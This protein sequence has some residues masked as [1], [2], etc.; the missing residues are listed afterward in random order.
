M[1]IVTWQVR[2]QWQA[3]ALGCLP[4]NLW[5]I[6]GWPSAHWTQGTKPCRGHAINILGIVWCVWSVTFPRFQPSSVI[7]GSTINR[8]VIGSNSTWGDLIHSKLTNL[9][10]TLT[11]K[12]KF[13]FL[14]LFLS[15]CIPFCFERF[16]NDC[17]YLDVGPKNHLLHI[18]WV[19]GQALT[20]RH[21]K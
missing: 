15:H 2:A 9:G 14:C 7:E 20:D 11:V 5:F 4:I 12:D 16:V 1:A 6:G 18:H 17:E 19:L 13:L 3:W 8:F 21:D 10:F